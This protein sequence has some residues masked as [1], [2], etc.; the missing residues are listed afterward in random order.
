MGSD[1]FDDGFTYPEP[2]VSANIAGEQT[3]GICVI[4]GAKRKY[5]WEKKKAK[6]AIGATSTFQGDDP[7][8]FDMQLTMW[9]SAQLEQWAKLRVILLQRPSKKVE[10][11]GIIHPS[12][13]G[14]GIVAVVV[15]EVGQLTHV[16]GGKYQVNVKFHEYIFPKS[17]PVA[18]PTTTKNP[19]GGTTATQVPTAQTKNQREIASLLAE[20]N[21]P[22]T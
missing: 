22:S 10:A 5:Q 21:R 11:L 1:Q 17:V 7:D 15:D 18:T 19:T 14:I 2:W 6:G 16:K 13:T 8:T 9:T 3:P 20:A 4:S 12:L